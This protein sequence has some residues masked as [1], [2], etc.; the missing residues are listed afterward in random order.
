MENI[1][2][3]IGI[4]RKQR[5]LSCRRMRLDTTDAEFVDVIHTNSGKIYL[6]EVSML[7]AIG[8]VDFYPNG[9]QEQPGCTGKA[10]GMSRS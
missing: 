4:L 5:C 2:Q 3:C 8:H 1:S 10:A 7:E 6:G 9:G